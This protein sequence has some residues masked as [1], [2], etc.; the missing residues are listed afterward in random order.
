MVFS[1]K[2]QPLT[3]LSL[4]RIFLLLTFSAPIESQPLEG[5]EERLVGERDYR[6]VVVS[7]RYFYGSFLTKCRPLTISGSHEGRGGGNDGF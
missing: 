6:Q 4:S 2:Y 5:V 7:K 3:D 1:Y